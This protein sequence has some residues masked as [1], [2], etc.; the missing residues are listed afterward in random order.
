M[1]E[2]TEQPKPKPNPFLAEFKKTKMYLD[3][4]GWRD[5]DQMRLQK[6][7][8]K[9]RNHLDPHSY[10]E[11]ETGVKQKYH[12]QIRSH[13]QYSKRF[14][15]NHFELCNQARIWV[16]ATNTI[17]YSRNGKDRKLNGDDICKVEKT[18]RIREEFVLFYIKTMKYLLKLMEDLYEERRVVIQAEQVQKLKEHQAKDIEC[19]CGGHYSMRNKLKHFQTKKHLAFCKEC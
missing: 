4:E 17:F 12:S 3:I 8:V 10:H 13:I 19:E 2:P 6:K 15:N 11:D 18:H 1:T 16:D 7:I 9:I 14:C 5:L